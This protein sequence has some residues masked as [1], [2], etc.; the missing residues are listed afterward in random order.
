MIKDGKITNEVSM[1]DL[2]RLFGVA[3]WDLA[4]IMSHASIN[5]WAV[6]KPIASD[7]KTP[8]CLSDVMRYYNY[9]LDVMSINATF[10]Q[11][12]EA[13]TKDLLDDAGKYYPDG[14]K[15]RP[16]RTP[17]RMSDFLNPNDRTLGYNSIAELKY[18]V[19][20]S[21][22]HS[23]IIDWA[24]MVDGENVDFSHEWSARQIANDKQ[25]W[26]DYLQVMPDGFN[27]DAVDVFSLLYYSP[28][29]ANS[30]IT[31]G[32]RCV[33]MIDGA[34][35]RYFFNSVT[36]DDWMKG[37]ASASG[38]PIQ[39]VEMY[40]DASAV[41]NGTHIFVPIPGFSGT[42]KAYIAANVRFGAFGRAKSTDPNRTIVNVW[43]TIERKPVDMWGT[44]V[45]VKLVLTKA[46]EGM[47]A[48]SIADPTQTWQEFDYEI[49]N[50][51][52]NANYT[53]SL[54]YDDSS[55][56]KVYSESEVFYIEQCN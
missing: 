7:S 54:L 9:G 30:V 12:V 31:S 37:I 15:Y 11:C 39:F 13:V 18:V 20:D 56:W 8:I 26:A 53:L 19:A 36:A 40:T 35:Y 3:S 49:A 17:Y 50:S 1:D 6:W 32:N 24:T 25:A 23:A 51:E 14:V 5:K 2:R 45:K 43:F 21:S 27:K 44:G 48:E 34:D 16:L 55:G 22:Q 47:W 41:D 52:L 38:E 28:N 4:T 46:N 42:I 29:V 10:G 33:L